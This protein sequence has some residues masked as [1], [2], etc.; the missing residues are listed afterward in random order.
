MIKVAI[1]SCDGI[2]FLEPLLHKLLSDDSIICKVV[3]IDGKLNK[4]DRA[5]EKGRLDQ[6]FII[7]DLTELDF[8]NLPFHFVQNHNSESCVNLINSYKVDYVLNAGTPRILNESFI[9]Q[10]VPIINSHPGLLPEYKGC[11]ALEWSIYN[12]DNLGA[13]AHFISP[14]IDDGPIILKEILE[15]APGLPYDIIRTKMLF[16]QIDLIYKALLKLKNDEFKASSLLIQREGNY[17]KPMPFDLFLSVKEKLEL[18]NYES[19]RTD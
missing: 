6:N 5:I 12:D 18:G 15:T 16:H 1:L 3:I 13:T 9:S 11:M 10:V 7:K 19:K 14:K 4:R 8:P 17:Y 2:S